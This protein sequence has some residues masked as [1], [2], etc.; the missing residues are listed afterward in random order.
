M[1]IVVNCT[2]RTYHDFRT[3]MEDLN[4]AADIMN[5]ISHG[6]SR[7]WYT[8]DYIGDYS[9]SYRFAGRK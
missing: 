8:A 6:W 4:Q 2:L 3:H 1:D 5:V 7:A 9:F